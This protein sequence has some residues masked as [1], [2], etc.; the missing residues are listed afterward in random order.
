MNFELETIKKV[1]DY[2][3]ENLNDELNLDKIAEKAGYS[4]F[5]L[6]RILSKIV[7]ETIHKYIQKRRLTEAARK[8]VYTDESIIDIALIS[9]YESQQAFTLAF[10]KMYKSS[11]QMYRIKKNFETKQL[12]I[13][14]EEV[15][16]YYEN[17]YKSHEN[18][19]DNKIIR[20]N[21]PYKSDSLKMAA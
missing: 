13:D 8:L 18:L 14:I 11:P 6:H 4:K 7:G 12:S 1:V 19:Y 21:G 9:G 20:K 3:E 17:Q 2:I 5:H 10:K 16:N 15:F